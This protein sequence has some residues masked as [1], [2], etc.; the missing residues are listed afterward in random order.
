M[1]ALR[2]F[3][4]EY[5]T[6]SELAKMLN[7]LDIITLNHSIRV[8]EIARFVEKELGFEDKELSEAS[9]YHDIG[10]YFITT[11]LLN[12]RG[13]LNKIER[14]IIDSHAYLSY[15][16]I[17]LFGINENIA[18][19]A[20]F[21]HTYS[22]KIYL[23]NNLDIANIDDNIARKA[24]AVRTIDIYE[25]LTTDRSY[26]RGISPENAMQ[27]IIDTVSDYCADT[28]NIIRKYAKEFE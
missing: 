5:S 9:L 12:K 3:I 2:E 1:K 28:L 24:K 20:L 25:A 13:K 11:K 15:K 18:L 26:H 23:D 16:V 6:P 21:H 4:E 7:S 8:C 22:P 27:L 17:H 10:K 19:I 14:F